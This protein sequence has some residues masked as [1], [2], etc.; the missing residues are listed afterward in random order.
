[1]GSDNPACAG[2][3]AALQGSQLV[4]VHGCLRADRQARHP[5]ASRQV[6]STPEDD[7]I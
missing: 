6:H 5:W 2:D 3:R 7:R 1:M 4:G